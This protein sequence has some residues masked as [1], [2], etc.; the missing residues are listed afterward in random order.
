MPTLHIT[1]LRG[2]SK[3]FA[4]NFASVTPIFLF[5]RLFVSSVCLCFYLQDCPVDFHDPVLSYKRTEQ[6]LLLGIIADFCFFFYFLCFNV[7]KVWK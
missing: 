7:L 6:I 5:V 1:E 4:S 3:I 2:Q